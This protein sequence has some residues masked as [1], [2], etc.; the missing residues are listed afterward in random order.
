MNARDSWPIQGNWNLWPGMQCFFYVD[1]V[2]NKERHYF[3]I[4]FIADMKFFLCVLQSDFY[5]NF[6]WAPNFL[7]NKNAT[8]TIQKNTI[9]RVFIAKIIH[10]KSIEFLRCVIKK[11]VTVWLRDLSRKKQLL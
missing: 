8:K 9:L 2:Y 10:D 1:P 7:M 4:P 3:V 11:Y 5:F 6:A